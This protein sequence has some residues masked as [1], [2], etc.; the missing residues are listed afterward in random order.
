MVPDVEDVRVVG[1]PQSEGQPSASQL[2]RKTLLAQSNTKGAPHK[3]IQNL[4]KPIAL[5]REYRIAETTTSQVDDH[6]RA[7]SSHK[8][9][10]QTTLNRFTPPSRLEHVQK[11]QTGLQYL[12]FRR[13]YSDLE[14]EQARQKR[15]QY[16]HSDR[17]HQL[18]R[19]KELD[20]RITEDEVD[21][22]DS[23]ST[24]STEAAEE[25]DRAAEWAELVALEER[26]QH[27]QKAKE[28]ERYIEALRGRLKERL[29]Q[30][31]K[32]VPPLC[33]CGKSVWDTNPD[34]CANNCI[35]YRNSKGLCS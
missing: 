13:L 26:K 3:V 30:N 23:F 29:S 24:L 14:R 18:K 21:A 11:K 8:Y 27:L 1:T 32:I 25:Q 5:T 34:T 10:Q 9:K 35:F 12:E 2:A 28:M 4:P 19:E 16:A 31:H 22:M 17:V 20:R 6:K 7:K 33:S 15:I